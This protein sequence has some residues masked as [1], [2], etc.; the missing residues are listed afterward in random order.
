ML[1][2]KKTIHSDLV[3]K[4]GVNVLSLKSCAKYKKKVNYKVVQ[5]NWFFTKKHLAHKYNVIKKHKT[6]IFYCVEQNCPCQKWGSLICYAQNGPFSNNSQ[7][8]TVLHF[9]LHIVEHGR[10]R[11]NTSIHYSIPMILQCRKRDCLH[12]LVPPKEKKCNGIRSGDHEGHFTQLLYLTT[13][14]YNE[15]QMYCWA[16]DS[17]CSE[18]SSCWNHAFRRSLN[19][20]ST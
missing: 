13:V 12:S 14:C 11:D 16:F 15:F 7:L 9:P 8:N 19:S 3:A 20:L 10:W 17:F 6:N 18:A 4:C 5:H 1:Y 2:A